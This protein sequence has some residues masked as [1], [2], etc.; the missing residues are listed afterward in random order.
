MVFPQ[1]LGM[2]LREANARCHAPRAPRTIQRDSIQTIMHCKSAGLFEICKVILQQKLLWRFRFDD[3]PRDRTRATS[4]L[5]AQ[6]AAQLRELAH[7]VEG[8][9]E[10][11]GAAGAA[12]G[13]DTAVARRQLRQLEARA[14]AEEDLMM[15]VPLSKVRQH[16]GRDSSSTR[17]RPN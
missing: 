2:V 16:P 7:E 5:I 9:P 8:A 13:M 14:A 3:N 17:V 12:A 10:E 6:C 15:R 4:V 11:V 1:S